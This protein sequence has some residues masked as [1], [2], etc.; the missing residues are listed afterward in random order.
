MSTTLAKFNSTV[1]QFV[2][3]LK[4][5]FGEN[6]P[7]VSSMET[8]CDVTKIN[9]RVIIKPFQHYILGNPVFVKHINQNNVEFFLKCNFETVT[10]QKNDNLNSYIEKL[11]T[12][13]KEVTTK[14]KDD[15]ETTS[16]FFN[17][18][19]VMIYYAFLDQ[20]KDP[21]EQVKVICNMPSEQLHSA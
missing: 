10:Q 8:M 5:L 19:K 14:H 4:K 3:D 6:D 20:N 7:D 17:W 2:E 13:F 15:E 1:V 16:C 18:F 12:K 11:I 21:V 9:A